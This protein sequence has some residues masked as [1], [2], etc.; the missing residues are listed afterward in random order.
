MFMTPKKKTQSVFGF[1]LLWNAGR[2]RYSGDTSLGEVEI[3]LISAAQNLWRAYW[4][5]MM[6]AESIGAGRCALAANR[7]LRRVLAAVRGY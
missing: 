3:V 4:L 1:S 7:Q 6:I 2:S 5:D